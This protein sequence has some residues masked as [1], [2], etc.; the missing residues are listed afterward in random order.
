MKIFEQKFL[1][2]RSYDESLVTTSNI[3]GK[4]SEFFVGK[5]DSVPSDANSHDSSKINCSLL[6]ASNMKKALMNNINRVDLLTDSKIHE[7]KQL[8]KELA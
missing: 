3:I 7:V 8:L 6:A 4:A 1:N 5:K 2:D